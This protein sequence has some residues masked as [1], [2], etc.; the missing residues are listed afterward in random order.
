MT[1]ERLKFQIKE[2]YLKSLVFI[3]LSLTHAAAYASECFS[4][5]NQWGSSNSSTPGQFF[6]LSEIAINSQYVFSTESMNNRVQIF[7]KSGA[8]VGYWGS[9]GATIG[10]FNAPSGIAATDTLVAVADDQNQR[11]QIFDTMGNTLSVYPIV[12]PRAVEIVGNTLFAASST[13]NKIYKFY[14][15]GTPILSWGTTGT[16]NGQFDVIQDI[17]SD[18]TNVFVSS[19]N[20]VQKFDLSGNFVS[21]FGSSG[22]TEGKF[23]NAGRL[24]IGSGKIFVSD[25]KRIQVFDGSGNF[26][27]Q[28]ELGEIIKVN[29]AMVSWDSLS[30]ALT[31][32]PAR[33]NGV[34]Q[35]LNEF[36]NFLVAI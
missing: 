25:A 1:G 36:K 32:M 13:D 17:A 8:Y 2:K 33:I 4:Y 19:D 34:V 12:Q 16:G 3:L 22:W 21:S 24:A 30:M 14:F 31:Y 5:A 27:G 29:V 20:R 18:G 9:A 28:F 10:K 15:D 23:E 35:L 7:S 6:G 11:I 26:Q